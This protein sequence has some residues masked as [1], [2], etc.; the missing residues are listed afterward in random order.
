[1]TLSIFILAA[2]LSAGNAEFDRSAA[3]GAAR[4]ALGRFAHELA[5]RGPAPGTLKAAMLADPGRFAD[6]AEA[7]KECRPL[8]MS[9]AD[10]EFA[11]ERAR[12]LEKLS[13]PEDF[14]LAF[15]DAEKC[16]VE[17]RFGSAFASERAAAVDEQARSLVASTRPSEEEFES[18]D[19][20]ALRRDMAARIAGEQKTP[21]FAEN[22]AYISEKI[23]DPVVKSANAERRRQRE[24]LMRV[25]SDA[26]APSRLASDIESRLRA[27]VAE[28]A[29]KA[30]VSNAWGVFP[31]VVSAG[32]PDAVARRTVERFV[33][34]IDDVRLEVTVDDVAKVIAG[35]PESHVKADD[36]ARRFSQAYAARVLAEALDGAAGGAPEDE[37]AELRDYLAQ[38]MTSEAPSKAAERVVRR[39]VMPKWRE[40]RAE[41]AKRLADETWPTLVDGTWYPP[42]ELA[43]ETAARSDY[44]E[45]LKGW[46]NVRGM[47]DL[48]S[49][50]EGKPVMEEAESRADAQVAVAFDLAR[51]AI[52]AQNE[53]VES[54]H[55]E[56]LAEARARKDSFWRRTPDFAAIKAMLTEATESRWS[57]RRMST[58]WPDGKLPANADEQHASLFPSVRRK[59]ELLAKVIVEEMKTPEPK[60]E[61]EQPQEEED[62]AFTISVTKT[63]GR[64]EA[65]LLKGGAPVVERIVD[66]KLQPFD[67]A[68]KDISSTLGRECLQLR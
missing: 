50:G 1:M 41:A 65:K 61:E 43:D 23:V 39:E 31:S 48:A 20:A 36:S 26:M 59:I 14:E 19:E 15:P 40:A 49:A 55:G 11:S 9:A 18:K 35:D 53:I 7:E 3:E 25:R 42:A 34:Q 45:A 57:V 29:K 62:L 56:V 33:S 54:C 47:E 60:P 21:V 67:E 13:L 10:R 6:P 2:A 63:G 66:A 52:A 44:A 8:Y 4:I 16:R 22:L 68:M 37:R 32:I 24:Y 12:V 5:E 17:G 64:V 30:D 51:S 27:N 58:L 38:R 28:R 46:R